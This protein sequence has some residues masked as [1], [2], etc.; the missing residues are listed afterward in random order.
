MGKS[1]T[2]AVPAGYKQVILQLPRGVVCGN[3]EYT[4]KGRLYADESVADIV[5]RVMFA[6][7]FAISPVQ[8]VAGTNYSVSI[9]A[10]M[11]SMQMIDLLMLGVCG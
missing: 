9:F 7:K 3:C 2:F 10:L 1:Y 6:V 4:R 11:A 5:L 8:G